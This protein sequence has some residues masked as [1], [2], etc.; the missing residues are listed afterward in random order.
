[1]GA[2]YATQAIVNY[3]ANPPPDD[4][5]Q[6]EANRVKWSTIKTKLDDPIKT[7]AEAINSQNIVAFAKVIGGAGVTSTAISYAVVSTDQ[8]KLVR[9]SAG[10]ITITT[11][12]ATDVGAPF[13]FALLNNSA[14]SLTFDGFGAQTINGIASLTIQSG[15][16]LFCF[17]DGTNW[18][19][20]G[21][22]D[23]TSNFAAAN[24]NVT[25]TFTGAAVAGA[26]IATQAE[27]E[28]GSATTKIVTPAL[29]Q[30]HPS[31][32]K[33]WV[34]A[35]MAAGVSASYNVTSLV[36]GGTGSVQINWGTDFSSAT[37]APIAIP[38]ADNAYFAHIFNTS[39]TGAVTV[40]LINDAAGT[41]VDPNHVF[42]AAF[43]DQ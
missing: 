34:M 10:G 29:Q 18:Y 15:L 38:K 30:F 4:G 39:F 25:A 6:T 22:F 1:M 8:G 3:N 7:L 19:T 35:D 42:C 28:A 33:G 43:G 9:A 26:M 36:D 41:A 23:P 12:D 21:S 27:Q 16:G 14:A 20:A 5:S 31:A 24:V 40:V 11:P 32:C 37:Y 13:V 17:T 2:P